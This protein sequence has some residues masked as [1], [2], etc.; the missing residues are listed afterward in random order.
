L[1]AGGAI[2]PTELQAYIELRRHI[3][4]PHPLFT[5]KAGGAL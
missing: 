4:R 2:Q 1:K 3:G 5:L